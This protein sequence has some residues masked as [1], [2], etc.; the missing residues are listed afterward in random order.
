MTTKTKKQLIDEI[1]DVQRQIAEKKASIEAYQT[2][3]NMKE[4]ELQEIK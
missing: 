4:A 1:H 3:V 2:E